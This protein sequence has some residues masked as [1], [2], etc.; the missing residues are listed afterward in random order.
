M[1]N[2]HIETT[3]SLNHLREE[4]LEQ[5]GKDV[6]SFDLQFDV[7]YFVASSRKICFV[8]TDDIK[9]ELI[10][11]RSNGRSLWCEGKSIGKSKSICLDADDED[12]DSIP[13]TK[14]VKV[15][16]NPREAKA[17][18][19]NELAVELKETHK[20][21]Y[22]KI[23]YKLWA[24]AIDSGKHKSKSNPPAGTIWNNDKVKPKTVESVDA[25]ATAFTRMADKVTSA[26]THPEKE[27]SHSPDH[28]EHTG[29]SSVG[30]SPG[31]RIDYQE[32][33]LNQIDLA[34]KM[35]ERGAI[36]TEQ[37][38]KRRELLLTQLDALGQ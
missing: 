15:Q 18:R 22:N 19:V 38:E 24:E 25:M 16:L 28:K 13:E 1:L 4:I 6:I 35:Y 14:K 36:T 20:E 9:A 17:K 27:I 11:L 10:R 37:F 2:L 34:H 12:E 26:F 7:G 31:R 8:D 32:K 29:A 33:L 5:L 23:Q 3:N 21:K 30:I